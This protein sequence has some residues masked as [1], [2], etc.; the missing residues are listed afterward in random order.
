MSVDQKTVRQLAEEV[1]LTLSHDEETNI[2]SHIQRL[3]AHYESW[4]PVGSCLSDAQYQGTTSGE[5]REPMG[6]EDAVEETELG[7]AFWDQ[8]PHIK[9]GLIRVPR[10]V[11]DH[12]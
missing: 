1:A 3:A 10:V 11:K 5:T 8:V 7:D 9:D 12:G 4:S 2:Q 6:R